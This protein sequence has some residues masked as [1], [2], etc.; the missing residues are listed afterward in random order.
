LH[1]WAQTPSH[2]SSSNGLSRQHRSHLRYSLVRC[3]CA[4]VSCLSSTSRCRNLS[5][6]S[7]RAAQL[8]SSLPVVEKRLVQPRRFLQKTGRSSSTPA[9]PEDKIDDVNE[10]EAYGLHSLPPII[11][12]PEYSIPWP[13][14]H[15]FAM[16]KFE[17]LAEFLIE[18]R[19]VRSFDDFVE[20]EYPPDEWMLLVHGK[21][22]YQ[23]FITGTLDPD[24]MR[25]T[26]FSQ[27]PNHQELVKR[28]KLE[29]A[30][31]VL[32]A[33]LALK[34][35]LS[36]HV[37]GGTHHAHKDW[38]AGYTCIN[39]LAVAAR[40][41]QKENLAER[42]LIVD[43]DVH[44]GDGTAEIFKEDQSVYTFSM[45]C[46]Q[47]FPFGFNVKSLSYL[48]QDRSDLDIGLPQGCKD[49]EY[50]EELTTHLPRV[51]QEV[52]PDLIL[53]IGGIDVWEGDA[54]GKLSI[55]ED[56]IFERDRFVVDLAL[57]SG[58]PISC[59]I[60]GGYDQNRKR[61]AKRHSIVHRAAIEVWREYRGFEQTGK[62]THA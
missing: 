40:L 58:I 5:L 26:G 54:L 29:V 48:G 16:W 6:K 14:R 44:Q 61:L 45:H 7:F 20:P 28:T 30:G 32:S 37:G 35:G 3:C 34:H 25:R 46:A 2:S 60:G 10:N 15:R 53:Y 56:G 19:I 55:T 23:E 39:D 17:D 38:G 50:M 31:T 18:H 42:V 1:R 51:I 11:Y 8:S 59:M 21:K 36:L 24:L 57:Q 4:L 49:D 52:K 27:R 33:R 47:N 62:A 41:M 12:H 43:C 13:E 22:Y 9:L